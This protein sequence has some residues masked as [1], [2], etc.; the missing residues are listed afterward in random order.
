MLLTAAAKAV[1][2]KIATELAGTAVVG[3]KRMLGGREVEAIAH[4]LGTAYAEAQVKHGSEFRDFE[5]KL[6]FFE[7]EGADELAKVLLPGAHPSAARLAEARVDSLGRSPDYDERWN[8]VVRLRPAFQ[9]LLDRYREACSAEAALGEISGRVT[10]GA[11]AAAVTDIS[12]RLGARSATGD[13]ERDYLAWVVD[14]HRYLR[15]AGMVRNS[16]LELPLDEVFVNL[17]SKRDERPGDRRESWFVEQRAALDAR[18]ESGELSHLEYE[19]KL[20]RIAHQFGQEFT[21]FQESTPQSPLAVLDAARRWQHLLVLGDPGSGKTT[22]LRYLALRHAQHLLSQAPG[23]S[24]G[25]TEERFPIYLRIGDFARSTDRSAGLGAFLGDYFA[26]QEC[27]PPGLVNLLERNLAAGH[28]LVLLDGLDEVISAT[29]RRSIVDA[30][31]NFVMAHSRQGNRFIVTSRIAGYLAAPLPPLFDA[32]RI[33]DMDDPTI[34]KFLSA[35]CPAMAKAERPQQSATATKQDAREAADGLLQALQE[36]RGVRRLAANPLLLTALLLVHR[37]RGRLPQRRVDAYVEVSEALGR[38]WRSVQG[39]PDA[40]LPDDQMLKTWLT[41]V[42]AWLHETRPEGSAAVRELLEVLGP[43]W[44]KLHSIQWRPEILDAAQP[45]DSDAGRGVRD[46]LEK[47]EVNTG[48]LVERAPGRYGFPHLTFEEFYAGRALVFEGAVTERPTTIRRHLHDPRYDEPILLGLG[49]VGREQP[50]EAERLMSA[51]IYPATGNSSPYEDI[52]GQ[53]FLFALRVLADDIPLDT[54]TIDGLLRQ[55]VDEWFNQTSRCRFSQYRFN[56]RERLTG[57]GATRAAK[58]LAAIMDELNTGHPLAHPDQFVDMTQILASLHS[59][60]QRI[61]D[62]LRLL[63][64]QNTNPS[65]RVRAADLLARAGEKLSAEMVTALVT[66]LTSDVEP[67]VRIRAARLFLRASELSADMVT[68]LVTTLTSDAEPSVRV[69]AA[70]LVKW[71]GDNLPAGAVTALVDIVTSDAEPSVRIRAAALLQQAGDNLPAGAVTTLVTTLTSDAEPSVR[72]KVAELLRRTGEKLSA[73]AVTTL[74]TTLTSDAEPSVRVRA[75]A[76]LQRAGDELSAE[77]VTALVD[78]VTSDAEP[79]VRVNAADALVRANY[80][81][82]QLKEALTDLI[83]ATK[84]PYVQYRVVS[85]LSLVAPTAD[86]ETHVLGLLSDSTSLVR[87]A[88]M[89]TLTTWAFKDSA[90]QQ[91]IEQRLAQICRQATHGEKDERS[92]PGW[93]YAYGALR[94]LAS[95]TATH[96]NAERA[97]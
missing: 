10:A 82:I 26:G 37:A 5:V 11:T 23:K 83:T 17:S 42:G 97:V 92:R 53:D 76:L 27:R 89:N 25:A 35:Y 56:L 57:L 66:T 74:V 65:V 72:V 33:Q 2:T 15:T 86:L 68:A 22:L 90:T 29:E 60:S 19:A 88:A 79:S 54:V 96:P 71:A 87:G 62:N 84:I 16:V 40:D 93:D 39:V 49:L 95:R 7:L 30:T 6:D 24:P 43:L 64:T 91:R 69:N 46:F 9:T 85:T 78:I 12:R 45:L 70:E 8:Q 20:D 36:N 61:V 28:C 59:T 51:A 81:G 44:A 80:T 94:T 48:L 1:A 63:V 77:A 4:A 67:S 21:L 50:E 75:A 47:T 3:A 73:E 55:A 13:D 18:L 41:R 32:V 14:R 34:E 58:R 31:V 38:T 52:L